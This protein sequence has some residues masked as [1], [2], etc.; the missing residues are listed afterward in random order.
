MFLGREEKFY[1]MRRNEFCGLPDGVV[2]TENDLCFKGICYHN[3][4]GVLI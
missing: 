4:S 1:K 3:V 2:Y